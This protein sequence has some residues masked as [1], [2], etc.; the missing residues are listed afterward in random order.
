MVLL[1]LLFLIYIQSAKLIGLLV[2]V[3]SICIYR[4][5]IRFVNGRCIPLVVVIVVMAWGFHL[6]S[7]AL[8]PLCYN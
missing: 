6:S 1:L 2:P 3:V 4:T 5:L 7:S 8:S